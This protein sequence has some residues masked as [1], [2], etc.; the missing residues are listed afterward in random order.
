MRSLFVKAN[1]L[2]AI[3]LLIMSGCTPP[4]NSLSLSLKI[5]KNTYHIGEPINATLVLKNS[6]NNSVL[7]KRRIT[8][9]SISSSE[10]QRDILFVIVNPAG[11]Q[12]DYL[13]LAHKIDIQSEGFMD[14]GPGQV[15]ERQFDL[16]KMYLPTDD[17][18]HPYSALVTPGIYVVY[19]IYESN[20]DPVDGRIAWKGR[21]MSNILTFT[22]EP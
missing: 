12:L 3:T 7:L 22:L 2:F 10:E 19:A 9:N 17:S 18:G 6:G 16:A 20:T 11:I 1:I 13:M 4:L 21:L 8:V 15:S 5:D 14:L